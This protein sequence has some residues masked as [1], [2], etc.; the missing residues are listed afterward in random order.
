MNENLKAFLDAVKNNE[1]LKEKVAEIDK[2]AEKEPEKY[3]DEYIAVAKEY[4]ISL[5]E[6]DF[7]TESNPEMSDEELQA[8]TGG[9]ED[10]TLLVCGA[11][12]G[13]IDL[14]S[15]NHCGCVVIGAVKGCG[16]VVIGAAM[17]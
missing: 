15:S 4:G 17:N 6:E 9:E 1:E 12:G 11:L 3:I 8:V 13:D 7:A 5:K 16:C 14:T 2:K 10:N